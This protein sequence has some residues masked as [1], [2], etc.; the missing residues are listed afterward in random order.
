MVAQKIY[1]FLQNAKNKLPDL[2]SI[3]FSML[4]FLS[5]SHNTGTIKCPFGKC[6]TLFWNILFK[7]WP[8]YVWKTRNYSQKFEQLMPNFEPFQETFTG[9]TLHVH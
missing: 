1:Q 6:L 3:F 9:V 7:F 2:D 5:S 4:V 8:N